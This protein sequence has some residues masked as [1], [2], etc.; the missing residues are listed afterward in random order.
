MEAGEKTE[1][2]GYFVHVMKTGGTSLRWMLLE[3]V[4]EPE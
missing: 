2:V 3:D 1:P 4:L